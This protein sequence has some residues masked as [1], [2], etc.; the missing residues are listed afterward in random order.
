[1]DE[2]K[3]RRGKK[4]VEREG[5]EKKRQD[6]QTDKK[7]ECPLAVVRVRPLSLPN[8]LCANTPSLR[9]SLCSQPGDLCPF[10]VVVRIYTRVY[11]PSPPH[12]FSPSVVV[13]IGART[14]CK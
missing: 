4:R 1:M 9:E 13:A 3:K 5:K 2:K 14:T 10:H 8:G 11:A 12:S 6:G 7:R